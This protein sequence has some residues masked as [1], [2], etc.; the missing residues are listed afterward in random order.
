MMERDKITKMLKG[1]VWDYDI[2]PYEFYLIAIGERE[3]VG[4]INKERAL[5]R[6]LERLSWYEELSLFGEDFLR[7]S[8]TVELISRLR[9]NDLRKK[10]ELIR[11]LLQGEALPL[12]GWSPENRKR[13]RASVLF[14]R[15]YGA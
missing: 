11:G 7:A 12:T 8:L 1:V 2:D 5:L 14:D 4:F 15:R 3:G 6:L 13:I 9:N 10:Y